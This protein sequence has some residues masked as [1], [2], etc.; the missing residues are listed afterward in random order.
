MFAL[1]GGELFIIA[2]IIAAILSA[3]YWPTFGERLV[4]LLGRHPP[5]SKA[6]DGSDNP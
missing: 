4:L 2:F 1:T 3:R 5:A 6:K